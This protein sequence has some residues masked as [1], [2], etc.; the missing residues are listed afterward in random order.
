MS[1]Y[2]KVFLAFLMVQLLSCVVQAGVIVS[3]ADTFVKVGDSSNH[4]AESSIVLKRSTTGATSS[5]NRDGWF[6]FDLTGQPPANEAV[7]SFAF[8]TGSNTAGSGTV[9]VWGVIDGQPGDLLGTDWTET[10]INAG[11][12]LYLPDFAE[13]E[14]LTNLGS[15]SWSS[16][17]ADGDIFTVS[18]DSL[19]DF[20]NADTND[21]ITILLSRNSNDQNFTLYSREASSGA[22]QLD[23]V[24]EPKA[25]QPL[26]V[27]GQ[28]DVT[29][30]EALTLT[31]NT[32]IDPDNISLPNS[33]ITHHMVY[34]STAA[35]N[36]EDPN[37]AD[38]TAVEYA[39]DGSG[40]G[41]HV[42]PGGTL[43][44]DAQYAWRV[45]EKLNDGSV[46]TGDVWN[47]YTLL[48]VPEVSVQP[49]TDLLVK[50]DTAIELEVEGFN[51]FTTSSA[52]LEYQW[53]KNGEALSGQTSAAL[54][55]SS[56]QVSDEGIYYCQVKIA[57]NGATVD[58]DSAAV[59]VERV[60]QYYAFD[61]DLQD[62]VGSNHGAAYQYV[63]PNI[64]T[65]T[66]AY[67]EGW[68]G[69]SDGALSLDGSYYINI[70]TEAYPKNN[71]S[72]E[73]GT[74]SCWLKTSADTDSN[75]LGIYNNQPQHYTTGFQ[76]H[77]KDGKVRGYLRDIDQTSI[78]RN[79]GTVNDDQWHFVVLTWEASAEGARMAIYVDGQNQGSA[80]SN[81]AFQEFGEWNF[82]VLVG[83]SNGRGV[84]SG[85]LNG[86]LDE[87]KVYNYSFDDE[88]V[89]G[90]YFDYTG[91]KICLYPPVLDK[92][93][94]EGTPDCVVDLFDFSSFAA[95]WLEDGNRPE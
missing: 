18:T 91:S 7:L 60:V 15:F 39:V 16:A 44:R 37:L 66:D 48:S 47:F 67:S 93:G 79:I 61:N 32:G 1:N 50:P 42:I 36:G 2:V 74:I 55:I 19:V 87:L 46:V 94:P 8:C 51:P 72:L 29:V 21:E 82:D 77:I 83:A 53:Y 75:I 86:S 64:Y 13:G 89:A 41:S 9:T 70:G 30:T 38:I 11:N 90:L 35:L 31:W 40:S 95:E 80:T 71:S 4:G 57:S 24:F 17:P 84:P 34:V 22:P 52:G 81:A 14:N 45:D 88:G 33:D 6:H 63:D 10:E 85:F 54:S 58:S 69:D 76:C 23:I 20:I 43:V 49:V 78:E 25:W 12:A 65:A 68:N 59:S 26:P 56:A 27:S 5:Y 73:H 62:G 92:T 28:E 3:D